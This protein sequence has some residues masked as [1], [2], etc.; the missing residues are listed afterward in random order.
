[1]TN[2]PVQKNGH[3]HYNSGSISSSELSFL[4]NGGITSDVLFFKKQFYVIMQDFLYHF[5]FF[6]QSSPDRAKS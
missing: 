6:F 3:S 5:L 1:M 4:V 2:K